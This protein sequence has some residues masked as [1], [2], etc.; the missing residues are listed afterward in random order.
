MQSSILNR[1]YEVVENKA[2]NYK[3][4]PNLKSFAPCLVGTIFIVKKQRL[5]KLEASST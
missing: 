1:V 5:Q 2:A 3:N 4:K